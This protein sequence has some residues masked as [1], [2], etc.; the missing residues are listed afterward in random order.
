MRNVIKILL[1]D[2]HFLILKGL[3]TLLEEITDYTFDIHT[4]TNCDDA[5][6][7]SRFG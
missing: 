7:A 5:Y 2:N 4:E 1:V 6:Q 3:I